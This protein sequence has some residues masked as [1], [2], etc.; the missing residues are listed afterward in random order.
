MA[1]GQLVAV[2]RE[3]QQADAQRI[4]RVAIA[5]PAPCD[6]CPLRARCA[7]EQLACSAF[8]SYVRGMAWRR[9][10]R[11]P[12]RELYELAMADDDAPDTEAPAPEEPRPARIAPA[13]RAAQWV[14]QPVGDRI[15]TGWEYDTRGAIR[16]LLHCPACA[17]VAMRPLSKV[18]HE[19]AQPCICIAKRERDT[20]RELAILATV[21]TLDAREAHARERELL[22]RA[23]ERELLA[24]TP[25]LAPK[26]K[27]K[28]KPKP[29]GKKAARRA[30]S[31]ARR[32]RRAEADRVDARIRESMRA[33]AAGT[34]S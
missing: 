20:A 28:P 12:T 17:R 32:A 30:R 24:R 21:A 33:D 7:A 34:T 25:E 9:C 13:D 8:Y 6:D 26:P 18:E 5:E 4:L 16:L 1:D 2:D 23:R 31:A 27:P 11:K 19:A 22:A 3:T 10:Q 15:V 29:P 14:G